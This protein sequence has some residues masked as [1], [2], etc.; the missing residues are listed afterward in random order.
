MLPFSVGT[1]LEIRGDVVPQVFKLINP[2]QSIPVQLQGWYCRETLPSDSNT[3]SS[4]FAASYLRPQVLKFTKTTWRRAEQ[5]HIIPVAN[6]IYIY[7]C[8]VTSDVRTAEIAN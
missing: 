7:T 2:L 8:H 3:I 5:H 4:L 1:V 6:I